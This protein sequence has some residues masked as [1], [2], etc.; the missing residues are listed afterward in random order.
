MK[1][2]Y[3]L[4]ILLGMFFV[5]AQ[6]STPIDISDLDEA[7]VLCALYNNASSPGYSIFSRKNDEEMNQGLAKSLLSQNRDFDYIGG[8]VLK[9][10]FGDDGLLYNAWLYDRDNADQ[11]AELILGKGLSVQQ[12]VNNLRK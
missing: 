6:A 3:Y 4:L 5:E 10:R 1:K 11:F 7:E 9:I 2:Y 8:R 12:I